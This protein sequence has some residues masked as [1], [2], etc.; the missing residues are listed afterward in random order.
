MSVRGGYAVLYGTLKSYDYQ[1]LID[2]AQV[3]DHPDYEA[4]T[5]RNDITV[6]RLQKAL[7]YT[8]EVG[9]ACLPNPNLNYTGMTAVTSGWGHT[10]YRGS[11]SKQLL[12]VELPLASGPYCKSF[13]KKKFDSDIMVCAEVVTGKDNC[14]GDSGGP[15]VVDNQGNMD[16]VGV[17]S[18][19]YKCD[20]GRPGIYTRVSAF[21][22][23][24]NGIVCQ[25]PEDYYC[26]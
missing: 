7:V 3:H 20:A 23:W 25:M 2:V 4:K 11:A 5:Y 13:W 26:Y 6:M 22:P 16:L 15:L 1:R 19:G 18:A 21:L 12:K 17:V 8:N 24:I 10:A 14:Q 9:P